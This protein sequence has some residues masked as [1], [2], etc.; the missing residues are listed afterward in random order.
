MTDYQFVTFDLL[1][2]RNYIPSTET[3]FSVEILMSSFVLSFK[4]VSA[5]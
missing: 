2:Y 4:C 1:T 5:D 3:E